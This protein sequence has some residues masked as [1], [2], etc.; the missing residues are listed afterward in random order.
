MAAFLIHKELD[1][2]PREGIKNL[3]LRGETDGWKIEFERSNGQI[4]DY[5]EVVTSMWRDASSEN[6]LHRAYAAIVARSIPIELTGD[7]R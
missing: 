1:S 5:D 7:G 4:L 3:I 6:P 2:N